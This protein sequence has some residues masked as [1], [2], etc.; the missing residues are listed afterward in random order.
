MT[1]LASVPGEFVIYLETDS[2]PDALEAG[3]AELLLSIFE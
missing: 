2:I 3:M 1:V